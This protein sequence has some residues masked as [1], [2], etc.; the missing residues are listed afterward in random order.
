M[1]NLQND[2]V[3]WLEEVEQLGGEFAWV[4]QEKF[5][6]QPNIK[7]NTTSN[8]CAAVLKS[9]KVTK[10]IDIEALRRNCKRIIV[11]KEAQTIISEMAHNFQLS[12]VKPIGYTVLK[13]VKV[14][15]RLLYFFY[16]F[17]INLANF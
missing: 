8:V 14:N 15:L 4:R 12:A 6:F 2:Y 10:V 9:Q 3:E 13:I 5:F 7:Q 17:K 11:E 1:S 16:I